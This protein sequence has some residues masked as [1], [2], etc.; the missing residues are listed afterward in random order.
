MTIRSTEAKLLSDARYRAKTKGLE[1]SIELSDIII[2]EYCPIL[3][4]KLTPNKISCKANSP[5]IDRI[6]SELGY[7]KGNIQVI[8]HKANSMKRNANV[9]ELLMFAEWVKKEY[10]DEQNN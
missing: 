4:L 8:S 2:P 9:E 3:K 7:V 1:F 6:N 10:S 5:S